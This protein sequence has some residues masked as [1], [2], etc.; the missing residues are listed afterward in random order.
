M[1]RIGHVLAAVAVVRLGAV[2][3]PGWEFQMTGSLTWTN[4]FYS[5]S[6][7]NGLFGR[8]NIDR[9]VGTTTANLNY[10]WNG[11]RLTQDIVTGQDHGISYIDGVFE[12][13]R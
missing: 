12:P 13:V 2:P 8:Y 9:G 1:T 10:W 3:A 4:E 6:G 7:S 11:P 5:Q